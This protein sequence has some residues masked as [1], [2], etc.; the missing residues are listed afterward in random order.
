MALHL[1]FETSV[2]RVAIN[3]LDPSIHAFWL[4]ARDHNEELCRRISS[5]RI[6]MDEWN[7]QR[8]VQLA[9][10][11]DLID[12][13]FST[14][15]LNRTNRSGILHAGV[16]GGKQQS[17]QWKMTVR[18]NRDALISRI[19]CIGRQAHRIDV[20]RQDAADVLRILGEQDAPSFLF[21]DPPYYHKADRRLYH[22]DLRPDDHERVAMLLKSLKVPWLL[23]YD[24]CSEVRNLYTS[25]IPNSYSLC[26]TA[27]EKRSGSEV[28]FVSPNLRI[29]SIEGRHRV[30]FR[31]HASV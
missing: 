29:P 10:D 3:D 8:S 27:G 31:L 24:D 22:N 1:L 6:D 23:C 9:M 16:I 20:R 15:F 13:A 21:L 19:E 4:V 11:P 14:L 12:L 5:V 2:P 30:A 7:R 25:H 28:L 26:Y 18:F 17:G